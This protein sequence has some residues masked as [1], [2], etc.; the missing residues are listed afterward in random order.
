[1]KKLYICGLQGQGK[2]VLRQLLDGHP[3][4]FNPG[5]ICSPGLSLLSD[6]FSGHY[7]P[8]RTEMRFGKQDPLY[9]FFQNADISI[10]INHREWRISV[11]DVWS[12]LLRKEIYAIPIDTG[13]ADWSFLFSDQKSNDSPGKSFEFSHFFSTATSD[14]L[15]VG[16]FNSLEHLQE[17]IYSACIKCYKSYPYRFNEH[18]Y[19]LQTSLQ[20]GIIPIEAISKFNQRKKILIIKRDPVASAYMNAER[21]MER[22]QLER[23]NRLGIKQKVFFSQYELA[24]YSGKYKE[25]YQKFFSKLEKLQA[26]DSDIFVIDFDALIMETRDTLD[27]ISNFLNI[28]EETISHLPT[29]DGK[30][31]Y[32]PQYSVGYKLHD[33]ERSLSARQ[34]ELLNYLYNGW[35]NDVSL[36]CKLVLSIDVI[37]LKIWQSASLNS[38]RRFWKALSSQ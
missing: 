16:S 24:L 33:P 30:S 22:G 9:Q 7:L 37:R 26:E 36:F 6:E 35:K 31:I 38:L 1:M 3:E 2:G 15:S 29:L 20:N 4:I 23:N 11:G 8:H 34:K 14:I 32:H 21:L 28:N 17:T 19:F 10:T 25:K 5:F 13:Y 27:S 18:S 12:F